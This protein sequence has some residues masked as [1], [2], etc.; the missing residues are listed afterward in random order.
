M[1]SIRSFL[2]ERLLSLNKKK[3]NAGEYM[4]QR[5][6]INSQPYELPVKLQSK[7]KISQDNRFP[8]D[9]YILKSASQ[10]D[11]K[12]ILF[13]HGGGYVEQPLVWHWHFLHKVTRQLNCTVYVPVYPK[14]P[15]YQVMDA[16]QSVLSVYKH[17]LENGKP[18]NIVIMGDSA[19]GGLSLAFAQY[20]SEQGLPQPG[21]IILLSPWLDITLSNPE[22]ADMLDAEPML[23]WET[24]V[25]AGKS[26]A[27]DLPGTHYLVSPIYGKLT[28]L[29][30]ITLFIGTHEFFLPDARKF[31]ELA[32]LNSV[33]IHYY[34][35]PKM[36]HV[37]PVFPIP[38]AKKA[39][40]QIV[41]IIQ[42]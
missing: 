19:G 3:I 33:N 37:F 14:A 23:D 10:A 12:Q 21:N 20:L 39:L 25:E 16:V 41:D 17:L 40:K 36:N 13:I 22:I 11:A 26:Y 29:A 9:T 38:E 31:R 30:T 8:V 6:V 28:N 24:L 15:N 27:G 35:Y 1:R 2:V 32:S 18:E 42:R 5:R 4:E 7:Y 34:E